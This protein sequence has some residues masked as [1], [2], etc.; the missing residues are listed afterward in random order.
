MAARIN[1]EI[2]TCVRTW[3]RLPGERAAGAGLSRCFCPV[4][5]GAIVNE[6]A[7]KEQC[8][9]MGFDHFFS[10]ALPYTFIPSSSLSPFLPYCRI[11]KQHNRRRIRLCKDCPSPA[12]S[13][14]LSLS[15]SLSLSFT[16]SLSLTLSLYLSLSLSNPSTFTVYILNLNEHF[17]VVYFLSSLISERYCKIIN[18]IIA[19]SDP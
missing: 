16:H 5:Q 1:K 17:C 6:R 2:R 15:L 8:V 10:I 11:A 19:S 14:S 12:L 18:Y 13:F 9:M 3:Q 4:R 7:R